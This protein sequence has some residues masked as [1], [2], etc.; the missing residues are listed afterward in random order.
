MKFSSQRSKQQ[1][2]ARRYAYR[3]SSAELVRRRWEQSGNRCEGCGRRVEVIEVAHLFSRKGHIIPD[4]LA[5][6]P[7]LEAALCCARSWGDRTGCHE[8]IDRNQ[9]PALRDRLRATAVARLCAAERVGLPAS[10]ASDPL[11]AVREVAR[12]LESRV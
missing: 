11:G 5:S 6:R 12:T 4:S 10:T 8:T 1:E 2:A 3:R 7:E 9:D